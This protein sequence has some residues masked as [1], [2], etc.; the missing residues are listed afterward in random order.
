[1]REEFELWIVR[2]EAF[3]FWIGREEESV[4]KKHVRQTI[5]R[6]LKHS[7]TA[8]SRSVGMFEILANIVPFALYF[9]SRTGGGGG[10]S[11]GGGGREG[12]GR[13]GGG[14]N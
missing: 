4:S 7:A 2:E 13:E 5:L 12:G 6:C 3:E 10:G 11:E 14:R 1:M 9:G 8:A